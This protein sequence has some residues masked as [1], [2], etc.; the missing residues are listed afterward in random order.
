MKRVLGFLAVVCSG[1]S[2]AATVQCV[3]LSAGARTEIE[4]TA[5]SEFSNCVVLKGSEGLNVVHVLSMAVGES[6][7][8]IRMMKI[9]SAGASVEV[10][11]DVASPG[12]TASVQIAN[13]G[14]KVALSAIPLTHL[15][16][17][18]Y[19]TFS[20]VIQGGYGSVVM[21]LVDLPTPPPQPTTTPPPTVPPY[22]EPCVT[23]KA[24]GC[25]FNQMP[26]D[27]QKKA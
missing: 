4:L 7:H 18:K 24:S 14:Q 6:S 9:N 26:V 11:S 8:K 2:I 17:S 10:G 15:T 21:R 5:S 12:G 3:E 13:P 25:E 20:Y 23:D 22:F 19:L 27:G 1:S 16:T